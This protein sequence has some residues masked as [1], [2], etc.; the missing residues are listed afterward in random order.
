MASFH[1]QVV[2]TVRLQR[3]QLHVVRGH[4]PRIR[5]RPALRV[6]ETPPGLTPRNECGVE[7]ETLSTLRV[8]LE[9]V[10]G[11]PRLELAAHLARG[12]NRRRLRE[13]EE[14]ERIG[15]GRIAL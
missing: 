1:Q 15:A 13:I 14:L 5:D 9:D 7:V 10:G 11:I 6:E 3:L 8:E 12:V 2:R 4:V